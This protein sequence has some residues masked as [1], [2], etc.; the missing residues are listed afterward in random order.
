MDDLKLLG[1]FEYDLKNEIKIMQAIN[2]DVNMY[3]GSE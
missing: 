2:K 3:F 1:S